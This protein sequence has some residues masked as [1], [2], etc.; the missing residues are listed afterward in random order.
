MEVRGFLKEF[1]HFKPLDNTIQTPW[2][3]FPNID[4]YDL[5]WRMGKG[6]DYLKFFCEYYNGLNE[7]EKT[8]IKLTNPAP[9]DWN[10]IYE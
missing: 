6:E 10:E 5:F 4:K 7:R 9:Y 8:I 1:G 2:N 3:K